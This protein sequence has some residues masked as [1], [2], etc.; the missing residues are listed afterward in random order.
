M[1]FIKIIDVHNRCTLIHETT[2]ILVVQ[3]ISTEH[4]TQCRLTLN[5][6]DK[7]FVVVIEQGAVEI[8][9]QIAVQASPKLPE[10]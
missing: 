9:D 3:D 10:S 2:K 8:G 7:N 6:G 5:D 1:N 4:E